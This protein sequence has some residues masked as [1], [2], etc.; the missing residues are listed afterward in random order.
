[1]LIPPMQIASCG[2]GL[3]DFYETVRNGP[4]IRIE[5]AAA[6]N[7]PLT[8]RFAG[9]LPGEIKNLGSNLFFPELRS[10]DL[11]ERVGDYHKGLRRSAF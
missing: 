4:P 6:D 2:I 5:D 7:H 10:S 11:R 8:H 9:V 3:P 1:M